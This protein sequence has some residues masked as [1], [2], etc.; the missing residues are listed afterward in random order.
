MN[1]PENYIV[2]CD[3]REETNIVKQSQDKYKN[4]D[5]NHWSYWRYCTFK[6]EDSNIFNNTEQVVEWF[7]NKD[8][9]DYKAFTF[10]E[11]EEM[12]ENKTPPQYW[13]IKVTEETLDT[14]NKVRAKQ[15]ENNEPI[16][17]NDWYYYGNYNNYDGFGGLCLSTIQEKNLLELSLDEFKSYFLE[18]EFITKKSNKMKLTV[19]ITEVLKIHKIACSTWKSKIANYLTR[20]DSEQNITFTQLEVDE[21]FKAAT[22]EQKPVLTKI[23]GEQN[24]IEWDKIKTGSKVMLQ[25]SEEIMGGQNST[26]YAEPFNVVFWKTPHSID[27]ENIFKKTASYNIVSTFHQNSNFILFSADISVDY[28]TEVIEY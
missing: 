17:L 20:V 8:I 15:K 4:R 19:S 22:S 23:F 6:N 25:H 26:N 16:K 18:E 1:L 24:I 9:S 11:W 2:I 7:K 14:V 10:K 5:K 3:T 27:C 13:Y 12:K 21:M 28:I